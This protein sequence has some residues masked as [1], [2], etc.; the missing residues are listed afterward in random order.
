MPDD[1]VTHTTDD[2]TRTPVTPG[3]ES[4]RYRVVA[5]GEL[6]ILA[7]LFAKLNWTMPDPSLAKA[8]VAEA[9]E[10]KDAL[11]CGFAIVQFIP[12]NEP[13]WVHPGMR[14]TGVAEGLADAVTHYIEVDCHIKRYVCVAKPGSFAARLA[15]KHGMR[16][17]PGL[18][19]VK[20][21]E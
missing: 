8:V 10:G 15:E 2:S 5:D 3:P 11:V 6:E 18:L 13:M 17:F 19:Y 4:I 9:G 21:L 7:P 12:H 20:Q 16:P 14:G 1:V